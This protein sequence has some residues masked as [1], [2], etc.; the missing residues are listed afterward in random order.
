M[1]SR[2]ASPHDRCAHLDAE[3][4]SYWIEL[5]DIHKHAQNQP[6]LILDVVSHG[7]EWV[8]VCTETV[9]A[10]YRWA[11]LGAFAIVEG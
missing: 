4:E 7:P 8:E 1:A 2:H 5:R 9:T 11:D 10:W 3:G 6:P